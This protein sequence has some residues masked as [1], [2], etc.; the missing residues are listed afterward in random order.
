MT[1]L[2]F[3]LHVSSVSGSDGCFKLCKLI[4]FQDVPESKNWKFAG[5]VRFKWL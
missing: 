3:I 4:A 1:E 2:S 5:I